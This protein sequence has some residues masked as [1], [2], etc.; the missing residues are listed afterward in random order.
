MDGSLWRQKIGTDEAREITHPAGAY[1]HQPDVAPDGKLVVFTRY[2]GKGFELWRHD[3]GSG[4][5]QALTANGGVN[6]EPRISP[7]GKR[8]VFVST[9]G[10]GHFNLKIADLAPAG[11]ANERYLVAPRESRIDRYYYSTHDHF[12]QPVL[13]AGRE[14]CLLRHQ[15][16]DSLGHGLDLLRRRRRAP[17][18]AP[19]A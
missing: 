3:L 18:Q 13:V 19:S 7:D 5:E 10:T 15:R 16:G 17:S 6:L 11:L 4:A 9:G 2:D 1:D 14:A 8:I 12:D